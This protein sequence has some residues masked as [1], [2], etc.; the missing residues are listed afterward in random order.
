MVSAQD[1]TMIATSDAGL[2]S[3]IIIWNVKS[4]T[5]VCIIQQPH[6]LGVCAMDMTQDGQYLVSIGVADPE[7]QEQEVQL[8][9]FAAILRTKHPQH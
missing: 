3:Q 1:R 2:Q 6:R 4:C 8:R 7:T 9:P 5:P